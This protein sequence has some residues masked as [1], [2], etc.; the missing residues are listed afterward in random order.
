MKI[1][2]TFQYNFGGARRDGDAEPER[3]G[4]AAA[5]A[6]RPGQHRD[7]LGLPLPVLPR[8]QEPVSRLEALNRIPLL[9]EGTCFEFS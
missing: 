5:A 6:L 8:T 7:R 3:D 9:L 1:I 4:V 2:T